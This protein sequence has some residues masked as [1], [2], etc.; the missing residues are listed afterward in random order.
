MTKRE[1]DEF[2]ESDCPCG[3]GQVTRHVESTDY[4]FTS[5]HITYSLDCS[6]CNRI[7]RLDYGTLVNRN[8]E[9]P[10]I[11]A[12]KVSDHTSHELYEFAQGLVEKYCQKQSFK[13]KKAELEHLKSIGICDAT[14][15]YFTQKRRE[16]KQ[17]FQIA[18]G[19][20]N[21]EWLIKVAESMSQKDILLNLIDINN[22]AVS[23]MELAAKKIIRR[24]FKQ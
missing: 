11:S 4:R 24:S 3:K 5:V 2:K 22:R 9:T 15:A 8:S 23:V 16:G 21:K 13:T 20:K 10:Y 14:Y 17:M 6:D 12:K 7:W 18:Y 19:L 1:F